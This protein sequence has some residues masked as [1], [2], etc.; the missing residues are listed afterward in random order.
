MA[1]VSEAAEAILADEDIPAIDALF[2]NAGIITNDLFNDINP[3]SY[4]PA[5]AYEQSK[6]AQVLFSVGLNQQYAQKGLRS[7]AVHPADMD[8]GMYIHMK[9]EVLMDMAQR[10]TGRSLEDAHEALT[11]TSEGGCHWPHCCIGTGSTR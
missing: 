5:E 11:K 7:F 4:N 6:G 10:I 9:P 3:E 2:N 1:S 8:T